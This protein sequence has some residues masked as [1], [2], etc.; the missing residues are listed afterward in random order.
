MGGSRTAAE[1]RARGPRE[2]EP[3]GELPPATDD[4]IQ[5]L[6]KCLAAAEDGIATLRARKSPA[7]GG[8][9]RL[10]VLLV[11]F[12]L[13]GLWPLALTPDLVTSS[14]SAAATG[15]LLGLGSW[16]LLRSVGKRVTVREGKAIA[17]NLAEAA[18]AVQLLT[19]Y[20]ASEYAAQVEKLRTRHARKRRETDEYY[21]PLLETQKKQ[22]DAEVLRIE[23]EF[24]TTAEQQRRK[25]G[26]ET[27][28]ADERHRLQKEAIEGRLGAELSA[29]EAAFAERLAAATAARDSAWQAMASAWN[30]A[31]AAVADTFTELRAEGD[32]TFPPWDALTPQRPLAK[33]VPAGV[34][35]GDLS[36][37]L[38]A[39]TD[40]V[41]TDE[42]LAPPPA[43]AGDVP[44]FLPFPDRCSV[45]LRCRD[46]GRAAGVAALQ[47]MMLRFLTG[48]P[49]GKVRFTI[50]DPVSLG[51]NFAAFMHLADYDEKLV[52][53]QIWTEPRDIEQRLADLTDH[54]ASVIQKYLRNQYKSI[55]EYNKA[56]GEVA[57]PYRVLVVAN[58]PTNFTPESAKRL[59]S[60][61]NSGPSCGVCVLVTA[62]TKAAMPRDF[63]M[64]DLEAPSY[65]LAWKDGRFVPKDPVLAAFPPTI[66][67]PPDPSVVASLVQRVG[68]GSKEAARVE[69]P[70][71]YIAPKPEDI[72]KGSAAKGFEVAVGRAGA[73]RKQLF[74]L[75]RGTAQHAVVAG[76]T[77]SGKSTLLHALITNL[78][79]DLQPGRG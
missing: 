19:E 64:A 18:R 41:P 52:T 33:R 23:A 51:D 8:S 6:N 50:V 56:A 47:S 59:V 14:S 74:A 17:L 42:R 37:D 34:R 79:L 46:D 7:W 10:P 21:V 20:A 75:G 66:D 70:F 2:V 45:L 69:V 26:S 36:V 61:A 53:S 3:T 54:T 32:A 58:F 22:Y 12:G 78:A 39:I 5:R 27:R 11:L 57:E 71:E 1:S 13:V 38:G 73:T 55:E 68:K 25:R 9:A 29:A 49:P 35:F 60:L 62:D 72:W 31:T 24:A 16:F 30:E 63:N 76:K 4:P 43:I 67:R 48:L 65:T 15:L 40:A 77:G 44:A 28:G